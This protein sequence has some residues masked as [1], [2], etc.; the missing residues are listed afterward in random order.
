MIQTHTNGENNITHTKGESNQT[1]ING[2]KN[3]RSNSYKRE[4]NF[5]EKRQKD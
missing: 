5:I 2:E 3:K 4:G 1:H